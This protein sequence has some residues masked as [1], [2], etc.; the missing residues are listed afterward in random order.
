MS[1]LELLQLLKQLARLLGTDIDQRDC[2]KHLSISINRVDTK[3]VL[4]IAFKNQA[5]AEAFAW[6]ISRK[7]NLY[8]PKSGKKSYN[9]PQWIDGALIIYLED[10]EVNLYFAKIKLNFN[11]LQLIFRIF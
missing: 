10:W 7:R 4:Q 8:N 2:R 9:E 3:S 1:Q 6:K 11:Q 5:L